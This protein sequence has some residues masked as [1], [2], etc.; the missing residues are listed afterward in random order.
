MTQDRLLTFREVCK[1]LGVPV[2]TFYRGVREGRFP[3]W[4]VKV[5]KRGRRWRSSDIQQWIRDN[6]DPQPEDE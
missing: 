4:T 5:S 6:T 2:S 1:I 3:N